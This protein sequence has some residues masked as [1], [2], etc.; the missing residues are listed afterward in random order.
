MST[1]TV[2]TVADAVAYLL[3]PNRKP[4]FIGAQ[5]QEAI[6]YHDLNGAR[7]SVELDNGQRFYLTI[8]E[9]DTD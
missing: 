5:V 6:A 4:E 2:H 8:L 9:D 1:P 7:V 3:L